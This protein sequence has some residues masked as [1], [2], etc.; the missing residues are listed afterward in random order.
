MKDLIL[1]AVKVR[2]PFVAIGTAMLVLLLTFLGYHEVNSYEDSVISLYAAQQDAYVQLVLDQ[3]N[4]EGKRGDDEI[5][6]NI[7]GSLDASNRKYWTLT[8]DQ[9]LLFVK[10]VSETNRYKGFTTSSYFVS[11]SAKEF[12]KKLNQNRV[13]HEI[14]VMDDE[15]YV[16]SGVIFDYQN[17]KYKVCLLT[18]ESVITDQNEF[19]ESK[20]SVYIYLSILLLVILISMLFLSK[21]LYSY[22]AKNNKLKDRIK[23]QNLT[24]EKLAEELRMLD[25]YHSRFNIFNV[26]LLPVFLEKLANKGVRNVIVTKYQFESKS[27]RDSFL[28]QAQLMLDEKVFRFGKGDS[29]LTLLFVDYSEEQAALAVKRVG[30]FGQEEIERKVGLDNE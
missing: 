6:T 8:K 3:I 29:E 11:D 4:I 12:L 16:A 24:I 27:M 28:E 7:L 10:N 22:I 14:V 21:M 9:A 13:V 30:H 18:S 2:Y 5:I 26:E 23:E 17:S 25:A 1:R 20:I 15:R 19:L